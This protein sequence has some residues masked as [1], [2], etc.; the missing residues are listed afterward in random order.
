MKEQ[1]LDTPVPAQTAGER[2]VQQYIKR[3]IS[4][5]ET[6]ES[7]LS[8]LPDRFRGAVEAGLQEN[9]VIAGENLVTNNPDQHAAKVA[10]SKRR[11]DLETVRAKLGLESESNPFADLP[12][13]VA[14]LSEGR[15]EPVRKLYA[16]L[17]ADVNNPKSAANLAESAFK[18]VYDGYRKADYKVDPDEEKTW[19]D[20]LKNTRVPINNK[21]PEWQYRGISPEKGKQAVARG[22]FN[23]HVTPELISALDQMIIDGKIKANYKFGQPDTPAS[24]SERNDSISI[25]FVEKP[26]DEALQELGQVI[27]PYVRGDNL[28]GQKVADGF[29]MS[30]VGNVA[31][32]HIEALVRELETKNKGLAQAVKNYT[33]PRPGQGD[34]LKMSEAQY[35]AIKDVMEAFG[36]DLN[37]NSETGFTY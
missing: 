28:L 35:Y 15:S 27:K 16:Q 10:D 33:S 22:S 31:T 32:P 6:R 19:E 24:P 11:A 8:G 20:A 30:E 36:Y 1:F 3:I 17:L 29:Y 13:M 25:Y 21:K 9:A 7:V 26:T 2:K 12:T 18:H 4:G 14:K 37:Y 34:T 23:V 5:A